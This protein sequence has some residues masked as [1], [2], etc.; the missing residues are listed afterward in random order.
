[1]SG[2]SPSQ[3]RILVAGLGSEEVANFA[4]APVYLAYTG[5]LQD[6]KSPDARD[7]MVTK[8]EALHGPKLCP[9]CSFSVLS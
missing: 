7:K 2:V 1:M 4:S 3:V 5:S 6:A 9:S 8:D